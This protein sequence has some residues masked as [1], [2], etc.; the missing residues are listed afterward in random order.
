MIC[1]L[2]HNNVTTLLVELDYYVNNTYPIECSKRYKN[3]Q[4]T[5]YKGQ[6]FF[7]LTIGVIANYDSYLPA[8][9]SSMP[10]ADDECQLWYVIGMDYGKYYIVIDDDTFEIPE[11][12]I[13]DMVNVLHKFLNLRAF[14]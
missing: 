13:C 12:E 10:Y 7:H 5:F 11:F 8:I 3:H 6:D 14:L 9:K 4:H 1:P 2:C